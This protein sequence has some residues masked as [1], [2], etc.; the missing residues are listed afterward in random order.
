MIEV[1]LSKIKTDIFLEK[2]QQLEVSLAGFFQILTKVSFYGDKSPHL[3]VL[4][5]LKQFLAALTVGRVKTIKNKMILKDI[6]N[7]N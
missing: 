5:F 1:R 2:S 4:L 3:I 6:D 7:R